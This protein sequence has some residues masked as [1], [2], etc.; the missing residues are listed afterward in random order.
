MG[1]TES[2]RSCPVICPGERGFFRRANG[3]FAFPPLLLIKKAATTCW[4]RSI[5]RVRSPESCYPTAVHLFESLNTTLPQGKVRRWAR[6]ATRRSTA[7]RTPVRRRVVRARD[8][9]LGRRDGCIRKLRGF[10]RRV[11]PSLLG[12][13]GSSLVACGNSMAGLCLWHNLH[14]VRDRSAIRARAC[15]IFRNFRRPSASVHCHTG[16]AEVCETA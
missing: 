14:R 6:K 13:S 7:Q 8:Y 10:F 15:T 2:R 12:C 9:C 1:E 16:F 5:F 11:Q 3:D 4:C